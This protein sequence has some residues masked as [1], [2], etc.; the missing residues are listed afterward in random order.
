M[1]LYTVQMAKGRGDP[2]LLDITVKGQHP[3]GKHFAP[4]WKMVMDIKE[5]RIPQA[6]Y[7]YLYKAMMLLSEYNNRPIWQDILTRRRVVLACYCPDTKVCHRT[8]LAGY[9]LKLGAT[10]KGEL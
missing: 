2:D 4:T 8:L 9:L 1:E 10:Y 6:T 3:V 5:G 7:D